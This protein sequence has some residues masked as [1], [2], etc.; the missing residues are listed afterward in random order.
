LRHQGQISH[1]INSNF[2]DNDVVGAY[3]DKKKKTI[4]YFKNGEFLGVGFKKVKG[5]KFYPAIQVCH[6]G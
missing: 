5:K 3:L 4:S 2:M 1:D 6:E